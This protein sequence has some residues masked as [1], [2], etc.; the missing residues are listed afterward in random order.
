MC[1][2][3]SQDCNKLQWRL[4][5]DGGGDGGEDGGENAWW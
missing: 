4:A 1:S 3:R 2:V 5:K